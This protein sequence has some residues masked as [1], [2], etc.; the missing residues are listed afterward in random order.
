MERRPLLDRVLRTAGGRL[1]LG[2]RLALFL[3]VTIAVAG[4]AGSVL[5]SG[6]LIGSF[7]LLAGAV[8]A[9]A[10]LLALEGRAP[11]A[12]G[13]YMRPRAFTEAA[14]G[15]ALGTAV[16]LSVVAAIALS[17]GVRWSTQDGSAIGWFWGSLGAL[18][19][20]ALPAAAEE[21]V[22]RGYPFQALA[23]MWGPGAALAVTAVLFGAL[24]QNNP[25]VTLLGTL[26]VMAAG[27][28]L[29]IVYLRT[30]S[31]WWATGAHLGWNWALGYL[32]DVPVSGLELLDAPLYDG[33]MRGPG[34]I[35]GGDF[36]P[37]GTL[38]ATVLVVGASAWCW[39]TKWLRPS[40]AAIEARP[41]ALIAERQA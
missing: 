28:F 11:G 15:L 29:G 23:E 24:H 12:L 32:A 36:G 14:R 37:E 5:P 18:G 21:A 20:L 30:G 33:V 1:M 16:A 38:V 19:F 26:N 41:L 7:S 31:L 9:G 2:W 6:V 40:E 4:L 22:F 27:V 13:F 17:G 35:G 34:W 10:L 25:G 8:T 39:R 3:G